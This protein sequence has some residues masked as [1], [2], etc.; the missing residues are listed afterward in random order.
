M[1]SQQNTHHGFQTYQ[2][3]TN[4][5]KLKLVNVINDQESNFFL[6]QSDEALSL[7]KAL[8]NLDKIVHSRLKD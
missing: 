7:N 4:S 6:I 1:I 3:N 2:G 8:L 5:L